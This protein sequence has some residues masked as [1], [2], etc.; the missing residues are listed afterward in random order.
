MGEQQAK[1]LKKARLL[2]ISEVLTAVL[3]SCFWPC[4]VCKQIHLSCDG[5]EWKA[6]SDN[7][8]Q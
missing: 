2:Q 7:I 6:N 1:G 8:H 4:K 3:G 5:V